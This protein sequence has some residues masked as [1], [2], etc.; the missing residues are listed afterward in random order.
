MFTHEVILLHQGTLVHATRTVVHAT[1]TV[2]HATRTVVHATRSVL[3]ATRSVLHAT[4]TVLLPSR[5]VLLARPTI[6]QPRRS[7]LQLRRSLLQLRPTIHRESEGNRTRACRAPASMPCI[8]MPYIFMPL[9]V[10]DLNFP[11]IYRIRNNQIHDG[12]SSKSTGIWICVAVLAISICGPSTGT[13]VPFVCCKKGRL[14][15][16]RSELHARSLTCLV[17]CTRYKAY[18]IDTRYNAY[19]IDTRCMPCND[20]Y[21]H[22]STRIDTRCMPYDY[23][24]SL[25]RRIGQYARISRYPD[26]PISLSY[27]LGYFLKTGLWRTSVM[28]GGAWPTYLYAY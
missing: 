27:P 21:R 25:M 18:R 23:R 1:R 3:H 2:L 11:H 28:C 22:V 6:L 15:A 7:L 5:S 9:Q 13:H 4:R 19:A 12:Y 8:S 17:E 10:K 14:R 16:S 26:I 20:T 24:R